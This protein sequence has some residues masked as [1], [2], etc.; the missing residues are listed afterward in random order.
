MPSIV[1][2]YGGGPTAV[3]NQTL[4]DAFRSCLRPLH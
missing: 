1:I 3:I 4:C 2:A